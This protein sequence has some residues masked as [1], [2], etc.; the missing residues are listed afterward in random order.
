MTIGEK[1]KQLRKKN[2]LTQEKLA[3][4][5]CVSYQAVSKWE[6]SLSSP[7]ISLIAPLTRLF[8]VSSDE[9]LCLT[10]EI[11]DE[12]KAYFDAE[13]YE[14]WNK[15]NIE[16]DLEIAQQAVMEYPGDFRYLHWL[17]SVEWYVGIDIKYRGTEKG[18][19]LLESSIH[20]NLM[21][22]ENCDDPYLKNEAISGLVFSNKSL[23][24]IDEAKKYALMY[25][26]APQTSRESLLAVC[27]KG[28]ELTDHRQKM[29]K[30]GL[31]SLCTALM[32]M[33]VYDNCDQRYVE[34]ALEAEEKILRII[35]D[36]DNLNAFNSGMY[37]ISMKRAEIMA[38]NLN[39]EDA[40]EHL[41]KAKQYA[42]QFDKYMQDQK[43]EYTCLLLDRYS[44][45]CTDSRVEHHFIDS[46]KKEITENKKFNVLREHKEFQRLINE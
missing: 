5:L 45:Y 19:D 30:K 26:E 24:R 35:I 39:C 10:P 2:D 17:A 3:D 4:Y 6:C 12:R 41:K 33:W 34:K 20:H 42:T 25:P 32:E 28:D 21:I 7:D 44:D 43:G 27:L 31:G 8:H 11:T 38:I 13:Y 15:V 1:I 23:N 37:L 29:L 9:L 14:F 22:L 40:I 46:W 16:A 36:D 18:R